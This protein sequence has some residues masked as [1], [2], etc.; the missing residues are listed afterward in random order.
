M[1]GL[2]FLFST[3]L[4]ALPL[5][6]LPI[7][8]HLLFRRKS[9]VIPFSTL[10]FIKMS[11]QRTAARK[12]VQRWL[13]LACR[14]LLLLLL[15]WAVAQPAKMLASGWFGS[16]NAPVAAI[17]VDTSYSMLLQ[18]QQISLLDRASQSIEDLLRGQMANARLAILRS[19]PAPID[20]PEPILS[21]SQILSQWTPLKPQP[22][23][24]PFV[25]RIAA[26]VELLKQQHSDQK[27]LIVVSDF[28]GKEFPHPL[29]EFAGR[30]ILIDLHAP[31][32][33]SAGITSV[34]LDPPQPIAGVGAEAV[35][36]ITG[37]PNDT[38][39]VVVRTTSL[40]KEPISESP[41]RMATL[42]ATGK[43]TLRFPIKLATQH[44]QLITAALPGEDAMAW[45]DSRSQLVEMPPRQPVTLLDS[46][47]PASAQRFVKLALD[48]SEG[49]LGQ[50]PIEVTT[51]PT[52][53]G[54]ENVVEWLLND[55]PAE[56]QANRLRDLAQTG[57]TVVLF[58]KPGLEE[59]WS[60][61]PDSQKQA[62]LNILPSAPLTHVP[63]SGTGRASPASQN[64]SLLTGLT[65]DKFQ[66][67]S[68]EARGFVPFSFTEGAQVILNLSPVDPVPGSRPMGL[69]FR[70]MIGTGHVYTW[71]TL[72]E[73]RLTNLATHPVFLPL[74]VRMALRPPGQSLAANVQL[75]EP[76]SLTG[77]AL[78]G[79]SELQ[80]TAPDGATFVV[81]PR[82]D[83]NGRRFEF[84]GAT[85][86]GYYQWHRAGSTTE[87]A[88]ANVQLPADESALI[89]RPAKELAGDSPNV[90][91]ATSISDLAAKLTTLAEPEPQ[92]SMPI[93]IV[94]FLLCLEALMGSASQLWNPLAIRSL[95]SR[96]EPAAP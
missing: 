33:R 46:K 43:A 56:A 21:A 15:I 3:A 79:V 31:E 63:A 26:G 77:T 24:R 90:V 4:W 89:T 60:A 12:R 92:W 66:L 2:E 84:E 20:S 70:K 17:V 36:N 53:T 39:A 93:A 61:L 50:W 96:R 72:P 35:V 62:L 71:T 81:K 22:S 19:L 94:L 10:R 28:Q 6:G 29:P 86:P 32:A 23:P 57:G 91:V 16:A 73:S 45:D 55:W 38:R 8:L 42:D 64:D 76:V 9:P 69:L 14:A 51:G 13:L 27:W 41:A 74:M 58:L 80:I 88:I 5:A 11:V 25:E 49:T 85:A 37:R 52:L 54:K 48:P 34:A 78:T 75:G 83:R 7:L 87:I 1:F 18:D 59:A 65:D 95:F 68:I 30:V 40:Q 67:G 47:V 44:W 82:D